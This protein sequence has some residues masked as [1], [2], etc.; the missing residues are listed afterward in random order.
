MSIYCRVCGHRAVTR[1]GADRHYRICH[2]RTQTHTR[3]QRTTGRS[4]GLS[5]AQIDRAN[6]IAEDY[7]KRE[8]AR[9]A[10]KAIRVPAPDTNRYGD[11]ICASCFTQWASKAIYAEHY[12]NCHS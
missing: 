8:E 3:R 7:W 1:E 11:V 2:S 4:R 5:T 6:G 10:R 9:E 12:R